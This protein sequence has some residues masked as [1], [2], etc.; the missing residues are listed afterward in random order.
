MSTSL[1]E[2]LMKYLLLL[3]SISAYAV[4]VPNPEITPG[5][6][7]VVTQQ[8]LCTTS[9]KLVRHVPQS[10]KMQAYRGYGLKGNHTGYCNGAGGC[11]V[12]HLISLELGG[13]NDL[14]NLW[15]EPYFGSCNAHHKDQLE[16]KLH[17]MICQNQISISQAQT[18]ISKD[19]VSGYVKYVNPKGCK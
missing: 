13:S 10:E 16:N 15:P 8:E 12:D 19:W 2:A 1:K 18:V 9:T 14:K 17:R 6:A 4:D 7:R 11:E 3:F 5:A